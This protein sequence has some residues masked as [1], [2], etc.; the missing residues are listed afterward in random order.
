MAY[1]TTLAILSHALHAYTE[2]CM[3]TEDVAQQMMR[4]DLDR[5]MKEWMCT[6]KEEL[7]HEAGARSWDDTLDNV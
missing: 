4:N 7:I 1:P 3:K 6:S 2:R 5:V